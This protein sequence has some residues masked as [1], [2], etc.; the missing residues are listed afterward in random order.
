MRQLES[1]NPEYRVVGYEANGG[2]L[3]Q[4]TIEHQGKQLTPLP[5]RDAMIVLVAVLVRSIEQNKTI[6]ELTRDL[7]QRYTASDRL[8]EIPNEKSMFLLSKLIKQQKLGNFSEIEHLIDAK[9][10]TVEHID[11]TDGFRIT[12]VNQEVIHLRPSGNAPELRC[13][14]EADSQE[15]ASDMSRQ[16]LGVIQR[17]IEQ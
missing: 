4:T 9:A 3:T 16:V 2:F 14:C 5:T 7:P 1:S 17:E 8:K 13:Y 12:F 10:G 15:R 6:S 11:Q